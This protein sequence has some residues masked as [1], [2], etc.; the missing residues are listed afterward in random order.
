M[1]TLKVKLNWW[2]ATAMKADI[3]GQIYGI[4]SLYLV[5]AVQL[6]ITP[7]IMCVFFLTTL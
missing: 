7:R 5:K 3:L 6:P 2:T 4:F 1:L